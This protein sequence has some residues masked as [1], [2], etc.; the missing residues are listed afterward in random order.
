LVETLVTVRK[1]RSRP[2]GAATMRISMPRRVAARRSHA[3]PKI[4]YRTFPLAYMLP[5]MSCLPPLVCP[6]TESPAALQKIVTREGKGTSTSN[7]QIQ[8]QQPRANTNHSPLRLQTGVEVVGEEQKICVRAS[9][10]RPSRFSHPD[11]RLCRPGLAARPLH[12]GRVGVAKLI[13]KPRRG[14]V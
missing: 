11:R 9:L 6:G 8:H 5:L 3:Q 2:E 7:T 10:R 14:A 1:R 12:D 4:P 13:L